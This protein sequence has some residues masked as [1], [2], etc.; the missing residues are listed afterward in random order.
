MTKYIFITVNMIGML[1]FSLAD[2][3]NARDWYFAIINNKVR[4]NSSMNV[5]LYMATPTW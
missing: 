5:S 2:H 3:G 1:F 4:L